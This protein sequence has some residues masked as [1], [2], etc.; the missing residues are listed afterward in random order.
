MGSQGHSH[1]G[2]GYT[3]NE[4][5]TMAAGLLT[6]GF[7]LVEAV[8]GWLSGSLAL[9]ADAGHMLTDT[10]SLFFAWYAFRLSRRPA[11]PDQSF[12]MDRTQ[13]LVA[14]GNGL[15]MLFVVA[16]IFWHAIDR[17]LFP[18]PVE[19]PLML[20]VAAAGLLVNLASLAILAGGDR[21]NLNI[22]GA[23]LHVLGDVLGSVA[24][25]VAGVVVVWTGETIADP[26]L[27]LFVCLFLLRASILLI[28]DSAR[29]LLQASPDDL[30]GG[31]V[32]AALLECAEVLAIEDLHIWCLTREQPIV[33]LRVEIRADA[34][35]EA[36]ADKL[37]T[38]LE[39][40]FGIDHATLELRRSSSARVAG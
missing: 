24:A 11:T 25:I 30:N 28:R 16:S 33:T 14:F 12:G 17:I 32:R 38:L 27:S 36:V 8:G 13:V 5:R 35:P 2:H 40:Q 7:M 29:I 26:I 19:G 1:G 15:A 3:A 31:E 21:H 10:A 4:G 18:S 22:R 20:G 34:E 6:G 9:L 39:A 23:V 37:R